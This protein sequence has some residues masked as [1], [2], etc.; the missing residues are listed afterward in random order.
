MAHI[1]HS[2]QSSPERLLDILL[3]FQNGETVTVPQIAKRFGASRSSTYRGMSFLKERGFSEDAGSPGTFRLGPAIA[4]PYLQALA[5]ETRESVPLRRASAGGAAAVDSPQ[6]PR[7]LLR[8]AENRPLRS[9]SFG[10][11][12]LAT[13]LSGAAGDR[14]HPSATRR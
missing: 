2:K 8:D 6:L 3:M 12:L 11:L 9:A 14:P 5:D 1:P 4:R 10:K 13:R 7:V